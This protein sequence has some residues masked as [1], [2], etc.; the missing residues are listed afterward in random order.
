MIKPTL[1]I[2]LVLAALFT[3]SVQSIETNNP[4]AA[5]DTV[6]IEEMT[7]LEVKDAI[8][9]GKTTV[10]IA[11]GGVEQN[12]PYLATGKHNVIL[13]LVTDKIARQLGNALVAP[14]VAFVPEG[15]KNPP[16][17]HMRYPGTISLT[18]ATFQLLLT[19]IAESLK[20]HGFTDIVLL[21]DSGPN[22]KGMAELAGKLNKQWQNSVTRVHYIGEYY[23]NP[24][25]SKW[26]K[27]K[28][29]NEVKDG[30]HHDFRHTALMLLADPVSVRMQQRV[31][32]GSFVVNGVNLQPVAKTL[33]LAKALL[34]YQTDITV[35][36]IDQAR[37]KHS[38]NSDKGI[39]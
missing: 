22:Q 29:I 30:E 23:D 31:D 34:Q 6:F 20:V 5:E 18:D 1:T 21:G 11:T 14:I 37:N 35:K 25:W 27:A 9:S 26:L 3:T 24:R 2:A 32:K 39:R 13:Q 10:I 17:K 15:D 12:G 4:I 28:G 7:W 8:A 36:A 19:E 33:M 38:S 16:T